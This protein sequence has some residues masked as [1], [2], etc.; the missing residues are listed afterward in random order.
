MVSVEVILQPSQWRPLEYSLRIYQSSYGNA[1]K[2]LLIG[3]AGLIVDAISTS[4][5]FCVFFC[6]C[7]LF[8]P[9]LSISNVEYLHPSHG[10]RKKRINTTPSSYGVILFRLRFRMKRHHEKSPWGTRT[11]WRV[12]YSLVNQ[13]PNP[14]PHTLPLSSSV[15]SSTRL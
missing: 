8:L 1:G 13:T 6:G 14:L 5:I 15:S 10:R 9:Y 3:N 12:G 2:I 4:Y 11:L 7:L